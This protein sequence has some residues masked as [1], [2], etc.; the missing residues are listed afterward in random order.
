M[1]PLFALVHSP[2]VGPLTWQPV[3]TEL[4]R[5]GADAIVPTLR[6]IGPDGGPYWRQHAT[7]AAH[8]LAAVTAD[9]PLFL[10]AHSGA[11]QLLPHVRQRLMQPVAAY[12]FV[13]AGLPQDGTSR[14][15]EMAQ[16]DTAFAARFTPFLKGG[17][18]YPTWGDDDLRPLISDETL[19][20]GMIAEVQPRG[21]DYFTEPFPSLAEWAD[22]PCAYLRFTPSYAAHAEAAR[23]RGWPVR[24]ITAGH[25]H[26]LVDPATVAETLI[27]LCNASG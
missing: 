19:R 17:G 14:L 13:D 3:A 15:D 26:M 21:L 18:H 16:N 11:G 2:I 12:L 9:C 10:I 5:R 7:A 20:R 4:R 6:D 24:E 27:A 1:D 25:F 23:R 22:A 8:A